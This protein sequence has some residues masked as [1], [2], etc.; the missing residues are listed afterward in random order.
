ML[1]RKINAIISLL[2]TLFL[3]YHAIF[4]SL[5]ML[6]RGTVEQSAPVAPWI[7]AGLVALHAFIGIYL[8]VSSH[9]EG[10]TRKVKSYPKMNRVTI[11]QR[12]SGLLLIIFA[13]LHI[14]GASGAMNPPHIVHTIV[15]PLFFAIALAHAAFSTDKAFITLGIGNA[16]FIKVLSVIIKVICALTLIASIAG[17]YLYVW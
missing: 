11:F 10:E 7:L 13:V 16:R 12:V 17:F 5:W 1:M 3:L 8:A 14:A 6:S 4:T 9:M 15:P 2:A